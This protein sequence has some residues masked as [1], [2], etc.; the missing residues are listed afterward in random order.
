MILLLEYIKKE[1]PKGTHDWSMFIKPL[2]MTGYLEKNGFM[3]I[4]LAGFD[5]KGIDS[6]NKKIIAEING[7]VSVMYVGKAELA[8]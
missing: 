4:E 2:Q 7:D 8:A 6:K 5:I 1:I 3:N